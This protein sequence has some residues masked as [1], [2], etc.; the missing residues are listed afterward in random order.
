MGDV[1]LGFEENEVVGVEIGE[2][3]IMKTSEVVGVDGCHGQK[4]GA[5]SR[6]CWT[7]WKV[8]ATEQNG[9][10]ARVQHSVDEAKVDC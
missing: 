10:S 9:T 8:V 3:R 2:K 7:N 5:E 1:G 6:E 4:L